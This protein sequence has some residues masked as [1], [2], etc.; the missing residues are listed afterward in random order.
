MQTRIARRRLLAAGSTPTAVAAGSSPTFDVS[1]AAN[2]ALG[3]TEIRNLV[4]HDGKLYAVNGYWKDAPGWSTTPG[5]Q[6]LVLDGPGKQWRLDHEFE[7]RIPRGHRRHIAVSAL[8]QVTFGT[9]ARG[10]SLTRPV[11]I[12]LAST[13]DITAR[14]VIFA[15]DDRTGQWFGSTIAQ[16]TPSRGFLPQVRTFGMH[17]D[18][19]AG[20]DLA[21]AGDTAGIF[22]GAF[23]STVP[24]RVR[25]STTPELSTK[26]LNA[27]AYPGLRGRLRPGRSLVARLPARSVDRQSPG[28]LTS[29][30]FRAIHTCRDI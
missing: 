24:C 4:A 19:R 21:F 8:Q 27:D 18:R 3:G 15:R 13:W 28:V 20:V 23:D 5:P 22:A 30:R 10:I 6:I 17:R 1:F 25:W 2:G 12:L 7:E 29:A 26:N 14:R 11:S 16:D 9:D